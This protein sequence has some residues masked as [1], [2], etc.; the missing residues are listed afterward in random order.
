MR[1][2][3]RR[4]FDIGRRAAAFGIVVATL[5]ALAGGWNGVCERTTRLGGVVTTCRP[6]HVTDALV[7]GL[8]ALV[9]LLMGPD[10]G[11]IGVPGL[12][13]IRRQVAEQRTQLEAERSRRAVL[14]SEIN[15]LT[16]LVANQRQD[17]SQ[18][19]SQH[20]DAIGVVVVD[21]ARTSGYASGGEG[22]PAR[23]EGDPLSQ[24]RYTA[25]EMV[26]SWLRGD[27][28]GRLEGCDL[29]LYLPDDTGATLQPVFAEDAE[30]AE[31]RWAVGEGL[32]GRAWRDR[33]AVLAR[34]DDLADVVSA[35]PENQRGRHAGYAVMAATPILN[36]TGR[37]VGVLS[38][39]VAD[40][41]TDLDS[42]GGMSE[43]IALGG[44]LARILVDLLGWAT[45]T[46]LTGTG[47]R[48]HPEI[49]EPNGERHDG[50]AAP[51]VWVEP[52]GADQ[53]GL[54]RVTPATPFRPLV[55]PDGPSEPAG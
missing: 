29:R 47:G 11:E 40:A 55:P 37:P 28:P 49:P 41:E 46:A 9:L 36:A 31:E 22:Q 52:T 13:S 5:V 27:P 6:P 17:Q 18:V 38:A 16:A 10:L 35:L 20:A 4:A 39:S 30:V 25:A 43:L 33:E 44:V 23:P 32:V 1:T 12:F 2:G 50:P 54:G 8:G 24:S 19:Q 51:T 26:I 15:S 3:A 21:G 14:E 34:G 45:D 7:M 53:P 42:D 48:A